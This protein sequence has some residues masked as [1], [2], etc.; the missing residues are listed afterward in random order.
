MSE[1]HYA[2]D[3]WTPPGLLS[4]LPDTYLWATQISGSIMLHL[5]SKQKSFQK[6]LPDFTTELLRGA[7]FSGPTGN[8]RHTTAEH[9]A[10]TLTNTLK[11]QNFRHIRVH[12]ADLDL[13]SPSEVFSAVASIDKCLKE[14][15]GL[16]LLLDEP[17]ECR[18]SRMLQS[19]LLVLMDR[20]RRNH[21]QKHFFVII[22]TDTLDSILPG[23]RSRLMLCHCPNPSVDDRRQWLSRQLRSGPHLVPD[24]MRAADLAEKTEGFSWH[25]LQ[26]LITNLRNQLFW[27]VKTRTEQDARDAIAQAGDISEEEEQHIN[28]QHI[29]MKNRISLIEKNEGTPTVT[30]L[31]SLLLTLKEQLPPAQAA[32][33]VYQYQGLPIQA[34]VPGN[35]TEAPLDTDAAAASKSIAKEETFDKDEAEMKRSLHEEIYRN[36]NASL[37]LLTSSLSRLRIP[38]ISDIDGSAPD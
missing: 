15:D 13:E 3:L 37:E 20:T 28:A 2:C 17:Q 26:C 12:G 35:Q 29:G 34:A 31:E 32:V 10:G 19:R 21:P 6:R 4:K 5:Y 38:D 24:E 11:L 7:I 8:G 36:E 30:E 22:V 25:Q 14:A 16:C 1:L 18:H 33:P 23:L 9:L 27:N